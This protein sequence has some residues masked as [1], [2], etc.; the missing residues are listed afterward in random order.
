M[1]S[2]LEAGGRPKSDPLSAVLDTF[3][4]RLTAA[5]EIALQAPWSIALNRSGPCFYAITEGECWFR[6][7]DRPKTH[8]LCGDV[9]VL[10]LGGFHGLSDS[11]AGLHNAPG[12][13]ATGSLTAGPLTSEDPF[14]DAS[15]DR[16]ENAKCAARILYG[17]YD[18]R[19]PTPHPICRAM[20]QVIHLRHTLDSHC[21]PVLAAVLPALSELLEDDRAGTPS[22]VDRL[23]QIVFSEVFRK[24]LPPA[25]DNGTC[26]L[27]HAICDSE[28]GPVI[29]LIHQMPAHP[30]S[31]TSLA[32]E[33]CMSRSLFARRFKEL[34]GVSAI[35]YVA[36]LRMRRACKLLALP[37]EGLKGIAARTGYGSATSFST[38]FKRWSGMSP[39][40]YRAQV[41]NPTPAA[42]N[43]ARCHAIAEAS[44]T[45]SQ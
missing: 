24:S 18:F 30:W 42:D 20:P 41:L 43:E 35:E 26:G 31:L 9:V 36:D 14:C 40:E 45:K 16:C 6:G 1:D 29:G 19:S 17:H 33:A 12:S 38:A 37:D 27:L 3:A 22:I 2:L 11:P 25:S 15:P 28:L 23:G 4:L 13:L 7:G 8:L 34:V 21:E 32:A 39:S 5:R 10:P 44:M